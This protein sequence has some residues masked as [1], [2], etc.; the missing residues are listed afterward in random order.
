[1]A[2]QF[3]WLKLKDNFFTTK[4]IKRLRKV[5]GGDTF[6]II[7][8]K[9]Q[10]LSLQNKGTLYFEGYE[11]TFAKELALELDEEVDNIEVTFQYLLQHGLIEVK[12]DE[13]FLL[14]QTVNSIASE[15]VSAERVR[16]H[17]NK[18]R[19]LQSNTE[20]QDK[21]QKALQCNTNVTNIAQSDSNI[22]GMLQCNGAVTKCNTEIEID[23]EIF[24]QR[25]G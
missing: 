3:F 8:L 23:I 17:R 12:S 11:E 1:M 4:E 25:R 19:A 24:I 13:E 2:K 14:P 5:A 15:S 7:Y 10:L 6:V 22:E 20:E 9:M 18:L 21:G 16:K